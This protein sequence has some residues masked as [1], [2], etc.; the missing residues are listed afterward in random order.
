MLLAISRKK[1]FVE[2]TECNSEKCNRFTEKRKTDVKVK[3]QNPDR[4]QKS[5]L[6]D[7][8]FLFHAR[9]CTIFCTTIQ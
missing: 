7:F 2:D 8:I 9:C 5:K 6:R 3:C 4:R 1:R